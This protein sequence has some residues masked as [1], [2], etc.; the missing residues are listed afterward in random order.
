MPTVSTHA[1]AADRLAARAALAARA[2][3]QLSTAVKNRILR[4]WAAG[5]IAHAPAILRANARDCHAGAAAG[6]PAAM[7]DRLRLDRSRLAKIA[8][9][10]RAVAALPDP[11]G[12]VISRT[13]RP[14]KLRIAKIRVPLG[15]IL[16]IFE[17]RP[18]VTVEAAALC[19]KSGNACILRG[20]KE[21]QHSNR[22][23][24]SV[25]SATLRKHKVPSEGVSY[26]TVQDR[27]F[28][29]ELLQRSD[30]IDL[31]IPR[32]GESLI[33]A[34]AESSRIPV[35]K[36][37]KGVCHVYVDKAADLAMARRIAINAKTQRPGVCNAAECLL[38]HKSVAAKFLPSLMAD[39]QTKH[40]EVRAEKTARKYMP[41]AKSAQPA[42]FGHEFLDLILAVKVVGSLDEALAHIARYGS[43]HTE[44]IVTRDKRAQQRFRRE[45][46]AA[47][48]HINASTR[49]ADGFEY[50]L[51]AE[52]GIS[53]DKL[54]ARGPM[55]LE[56]L[57]TY[58]YVLDGNGQVRE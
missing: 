26:V 42:D 48:V 21:A 3:A 30:K 58:K 5:L 16:I 14:N 15:T 2:M 56:E 29:T 43:Q 19:L 45:V 50:G 54:H 23:I 47:C 8:A 55:G 11:V 53:T 28:V 4:A 9:G 6:L 20:G 52:I 36:H 37:Y 41:G 31:V 18:N 12:R 57:T 1:K 13:V 34:V 51:G 46:D 22:A 33:R 7:I 44:A 10:L 49:F 38:V 17:S 27:A 40:C 25:L 24:C 35:I 32:G 39:L